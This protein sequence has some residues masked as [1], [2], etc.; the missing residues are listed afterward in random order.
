M[1]RNTNRSETSKNSRKLILFGLML[2]GV[3]L[4]MYV[5]FILTI[6]FKGQ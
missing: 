6:A 5:S 2:G 3:S 4:F 1:E